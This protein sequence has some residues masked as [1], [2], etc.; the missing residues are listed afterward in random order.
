MSLKSDAN[1]LINAFFSHIADYLEVIY[2]QKTISPASG[3]S[4]KLSC[5]ANYDFDKCGVLHV[6]WHRIQEGTEK[7][8]ELIDPSRYFTTVNETITTERMRRRQ[9]LTEIISVKP[10]DDGR[11]QCKASCESGEQAMG[12][13]ITINSSLTWSG[14]LLLVGYRIWSLTELNT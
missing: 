4:A 8:T 9:V 14:K 6:V 2:Q 3:S 7:S 12:H 10:N 13:F 5:E 1:L 11:Y